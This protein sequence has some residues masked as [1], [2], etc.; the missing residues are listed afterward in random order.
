MIEAYCYQ[1]PKLPTKGPSTTKINELNESFDVK[2]HLG[3][4][5]FLLEQTYLVSTNTLRS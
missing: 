3:K 4:Y 1:Q 5:N 2:T